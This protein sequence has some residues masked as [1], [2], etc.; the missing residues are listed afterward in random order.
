MRSSAPT[1]R[2]AA[3]ADGADD[4]IEEGLMASLRIQVEIHEARVARRRRRI[5]C[6]LAAVLAS[7][8]GRIRGG[9]EG[10]T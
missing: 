3:A 5:M 7:V 10:R 2:L 1:L 4:E 6:G 9:R 8:C